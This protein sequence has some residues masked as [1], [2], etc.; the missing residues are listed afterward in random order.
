MKP[1]THDKAQGTEKLIAG[2]AKEVA[3]RL[4]GNHPLQASGKAEKVEGRVQKKIGNIK[5]THGN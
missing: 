4:L 2:T 5:K 1:S 3:G